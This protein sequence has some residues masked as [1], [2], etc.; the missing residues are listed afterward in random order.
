MFVGGLND[1]IDQEEL[2]AMFL[3]KGSIVEYKFVRKFAFFTYDDS[4][5]NLRM[6]FYEI[7]E[8]IHEL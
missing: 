2:I 7:S 6:E 4:G 5:N 3:A 1:D 8:L